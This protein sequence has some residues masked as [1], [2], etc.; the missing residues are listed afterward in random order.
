MGSPVVLD[1]TLV[2]GGFRPAFSRSCASREG[3]AAVL[4]ATGLSITGL[5]WGEAR[6]SSA[7]ESQRELC[8][9]WKMPTASPSPVLLCFRCTDLTACCI[10]SLS[11]P[12]SDISLTPGALIMLR[13]F[14]ARAELSAEEEQPRASS[15]LETLLCQAWKGGH[16]GRKVVEQPEQGGQHIQMPSLQSGWH[17]CFPAGLL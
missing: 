1:H 6:P 8:S 9:A 5:L 11:F 14:L 3:I 15:A 13:Y 2:S 7:A 10:F 12:F 17:P 16:L 4:P